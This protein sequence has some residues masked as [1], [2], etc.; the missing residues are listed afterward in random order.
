MLKHRPNL[1]YTE[2][3]L[4]EIVPRL[5]RNAVKDALSSSLNKSSITIM[6]PEFPQKV[7]SFFAEIIPE[8]AVTKGR[9]WITSKLYTLKGELCTLER[10]KLILL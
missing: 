3:F 2:L 7:T 9:K 8:E 10:Y 1:D 5:N 6:D 4:K